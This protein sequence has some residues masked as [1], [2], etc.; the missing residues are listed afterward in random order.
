MD[1]AD[2]F[3]AGSVMYSTGD[4][5]GAVDKFSRMTSRADSI[6][7]IANYEMAYSYIKTGNKVAAMDAFKAASS[8]PWNESAATPPIRSA[9]LS[10]FDSFRLF[11][12]L[13]PFN[14]YNC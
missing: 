7:Q 9:S 6:G 3:Y 11:V 4:Y 13:F 10:H 14:R 12:A 2:L 8:Q 5:K 1:D